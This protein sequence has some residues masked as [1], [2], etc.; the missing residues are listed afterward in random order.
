MRG[1]GMPVLNTSRF[2]DHYVTVTVEIPKKLTGEQEAL[3]RQFAAAGAKKKEPPK[4]EAEDPG[5]R[6]FGLF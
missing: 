5:K 2:G 3:M 6:L 1:K 4:S